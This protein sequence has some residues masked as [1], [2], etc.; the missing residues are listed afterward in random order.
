MPTER[1][2]QYI[3]LST[4]YWLCQN[5][6]HSISDLKEVHALMRKISILHYQMNNKRMPIT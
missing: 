3:Q 5:Q 1:I 4:S 6:N 2:I